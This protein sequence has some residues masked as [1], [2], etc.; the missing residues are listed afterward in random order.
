MSCPHAPRCAPEISRWI[1][2]KRTE[3]EQAVKDGGVSREEAG[4]LLATYGVPMSAIQRVYRGEES[5][6]R[7]KEKP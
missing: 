1:C 5:Y 4:K 3:I 7:W 2:G 6:G